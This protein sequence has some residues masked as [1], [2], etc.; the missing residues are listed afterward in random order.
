MI[1]IIHKIY[2][3]YSII[4]EHKFKKKNK[5]IHGS[6]INY[7]VLVMINTKINALRNICYLKS[8]QNYLI[9]FP[10][11]KRNVSLSIFVLFY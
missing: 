9:G 6:I 10:L 4:Q 2:V 5:L 7:H 1:G 3:R 11:V 8:V